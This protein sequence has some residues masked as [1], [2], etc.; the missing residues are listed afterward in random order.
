MYSIQL[1]KSEKK[2]IITVIKP[3]LLS[4]CLYTVFVLSYYIVLQD[5]EAAPV[6]LTFTSFPV[7]LYIIRFFKSMALVLICLDPIGQKVLPAMWV[8]RLWDWVICVHNLKQ[9]TFYQC[10]EPQYVPQIRQC[11]TQGQ[12]KEHH[13]IC[14]AQVGPE[15]PQGCR[16][17]EAS[18]SAR[19]VYGCAAQLRHSRSPWSY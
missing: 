17:S 9:L 10:K 3:S 19:L 5:L 15:A 1:Q 16:S 18:S 8:L 13:L 2:R 14:G 12:I 4:V 6:L 7:C 11:Q